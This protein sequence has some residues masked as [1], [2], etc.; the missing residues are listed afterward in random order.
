MQIFKDRLPYSAIVDRPPL[1]LPDGKRMAV[2]FIANVEDWDIARPM[3]RTVLPPNPISLPSIN[4]VEKP[5]PGLRRKISASEKVPPPCCV[6]RM[7][8]ATRLASPTLTAC[9]AIAIS[10]RSF[11][12]FVVARP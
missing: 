8:P 5:S 12:W 10:F 7:V 2:W 3:P 6:Y 1:K 11:S 4:T 9:S